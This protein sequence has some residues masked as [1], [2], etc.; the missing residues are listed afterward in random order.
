M[1]EAVLDSFYVSVTFITPAAAILKNIYSPGIK[2]GDA[3]VIKACIRTTT[4]AFF[5]VGKL[6][7]CSDRQKFPK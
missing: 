2:D 6:P 4:T 3:A 7:N 1:G 5:P